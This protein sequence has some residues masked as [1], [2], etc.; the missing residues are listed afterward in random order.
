V[1]G[2]FLILY[3]CGLA[4]GLIFFL[5]TLERLDDFQLLPTGVLHSRGKTQVIG[6]AKLGFTLVLHCDG[7]DF[8]RG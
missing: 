7:L 2:Q 5:V 1:D 3:S 4:L 6:K 8:H